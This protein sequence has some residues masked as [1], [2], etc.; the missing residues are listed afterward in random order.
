MRLFPCINEFVNSL[1]NGKLS[2]ATC[3]KNRPRVSDTLNWLSSCCAT[4]RPRHYSRRLPGRQCRKAREYQLQS[5]RTP[6]HPSTQHSVL[7]QLQHASQAQDHKRQH[8]IAVLGWVPLCG[9]RQMH[10][11]HQENTLMQSVTLPANGII[12]HTIYRTGETQR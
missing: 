2:K 6:C 8:L 5:G 1:M 3:G 12:G 10:G 11:A 7:G 4:R 9:I